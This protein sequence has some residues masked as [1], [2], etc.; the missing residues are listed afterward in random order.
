MERDNTHGYGGSVEAY[1]VKTY[2]EPRGNSRNVAGFSK[3][4]A[5]Q[6]QMTAGLADLWRR[7]RDSNPRDAC[8]SNG[9]QDRR[10]RPLSH[11]SVCHN[12]LKQRGVKIKMQNKKISK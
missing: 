12:I 3:T 11:L 7:G 6:S 8:T 5:R 2:R 1:P 10:F 9:F 4:K